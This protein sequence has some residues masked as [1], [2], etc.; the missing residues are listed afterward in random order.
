MCWACCLE[1]SDTLSSPDPT[2][3][4]ACVASLVIFTYHRITKLSVARISELGN[5]CPMGS[6]EGSRHTRLYILFLSEFR[7]GSLRP[8]RQRKLGF[9]IFQVIAYL[10]GTGQC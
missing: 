1:A 9:G 8:T 3:K 4:A 5:A 2:Q 7:K 6:L 10:L